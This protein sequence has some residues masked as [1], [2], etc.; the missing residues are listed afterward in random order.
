MFDA[1]LVKVGLGWLAPYD[2]LRYVLIYYFVC[3]M[4][5][6]LV[7][8][9]VL[10]LWINSK[11]MSLFQLF[12][13][14]SPQPPSIC[15]NYHG[16]ILNTC[17]TRLADIRI[18]SSPQPDS[19]RCFQI[20]NRV[21]NPPGPFALPSPPSELTCRGPF[22]S[23]DRGVC[24]GRIPNPDR[25]VNPNTDSGAKRVIIMNQTAFRC[26]DVEL[27]QTVGD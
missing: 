9:I 15:R 11:I 7:E 23:S 2:T 6:Y 5:M 21:P 8:K 27:G 10:L 25:G 20:W 1:W 18:S 19:Q 17:N 22:A 4:V 26:F 14:R 24:F 12:K 3:P 16:Y 13:I